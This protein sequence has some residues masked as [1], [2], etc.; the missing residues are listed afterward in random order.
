MDNYDEDYAEELEIELDMDNQD[1]SY[2][3]ERSEMFQD[4]LDMFRNEY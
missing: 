3:Q 1:I 2:D 4:K